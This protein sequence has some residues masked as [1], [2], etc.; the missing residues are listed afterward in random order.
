[1]WPPVAWPKERISLGQAFEGR[2]REQGSSSQDK[3]WEKDFRIQ[4]SDFRKPAAGILVAGKM[5]LPPIRHFDE[6]QCRHAQDRPFDKLRTG[7]TY[8]SWF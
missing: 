1:M 2:Q 7:R 5:R 3:G 4:I 6:A 8:K